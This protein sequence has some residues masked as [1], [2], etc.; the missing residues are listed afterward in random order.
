MSGVFFTTLSKVSV[1]LIF[2]ALGYLLRRS[3]KL[4]EDA[5]R[6]LSLLTTLVFSPAY[7]IKNLSSSLTLE[8]IGSQL[9]LIGYGLVCVLVTIGLAYLLAKPLARN[10]FERRSCVYA[11]SIPNYG[12]FGYPLVEGVFGTQ[13]LSQLMVFGLP[14]AIACNTFGY[15]LFA[16]DGR[17]TLKKILTTPLILAVI[18]GCVLGLSGLELP[19]IVTDVLSGAAACMSPASMLLAGFVL[20]GFPLGDL[21]KGKRAYLMSAIRLVGLPVLFGGVLWLLGLRGMYLALPVMI[22]SMPL[23]LNLVVFPE[24]QGIDA[25]DNAKMCFVCN[26]LT[27]IVLPIT[28]SLLAGLM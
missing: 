5:G 11:F 9:V 1:L 4:P 20:G 16:K 23:G 17:L 24:S 27:I 7:T 14:L 6:V 8:K 3:R 12:Y 10:D 13:V 19:G 15:L 18:L 26:L 28:F 21:L 2:I 25:S 22:L